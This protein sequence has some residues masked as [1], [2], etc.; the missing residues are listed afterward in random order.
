MRIPTEHIQ[1]G[2]V[3]PHRDKLHQQQVRDF[4]FRKMTKSLL[5]QKEP[6]SMGMPARKE[7]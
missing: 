4:K 2:V 1:N 7:V 6:K 3:L 5:Q